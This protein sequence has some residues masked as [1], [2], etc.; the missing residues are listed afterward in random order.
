VTQG[1]RELQ[2]DWDVDKLH[3]NWRLDPDNEFIMARLGT[4]PIAATMAGGPGRVLEVAAAEAIHACK[5]SLQGTDTYV[6]EPSPTMLARARERI[7]EYGARVHL[8]R[9][10]AE[11][12]P[13]A[14]ASFDRV[15]LDS[16]IDHLAD[17]GRGLA[18]MTRVLRPDGRLVVSFVNYGSLGV[19]LSRV[20]YRVGRAIG[21]MRRDRR[22]FWDSPVPDEHTFECTLP[23]L[24]RLCAPHL[25]LD[26]V[27]GVSMGW[28]VPYWGR[29]LGRLPTT[30]SD[31]LL[32]RL[33]RIAGRRPHLADFVVSVW[34]PLRRD[35]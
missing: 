20:I 32:T 5:M 1:N 31:A 22:Y 4:E 7:R 34:R 18:E 6:V 11:T 15:L 30:W 19:R 12:L 9:G 17:P 3:G 13:F 8:V 21:A 28:M 23:L 10:I 33:D 35:R 2:L 26:R 16:A 24:E 29:L 14:D 25:E 27:V